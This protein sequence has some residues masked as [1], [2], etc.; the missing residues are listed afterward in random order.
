SAVEGRVHFLFDDGEI[1][2]STKAM[3]LQREGHEPIVFVPLED[4]HPGILESS[5]TRRVDPA[6][7]EAHFYT[8]KTLTADGIDA[9][10]YFP[11]AEGPLDAIR[12]LITFGGERV[13]MRISEV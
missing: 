2:S 5:D 12:D 9:A 1:A 3:Q 8:V 7:G 6:A 13:T 11:Y 4:V 10:W